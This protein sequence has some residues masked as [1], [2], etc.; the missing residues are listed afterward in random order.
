EQH[1]IVSFS[2]Y[3]CATDYA[4]RRETAQMNRS[5]LFAEGAEHQDVSVP[6]H[7]K[8]NTMNKSS[9]LA[10][11]AMPFLL[12][13]FSSAHALPVPKVAVQVHVA[14]I[15]RIAMSVAEAEAQLQAALDALANAQA[16]GGD[17]AAAQAAVDAAQA[18]L[19]A[20]QMPAAE[21]VPEVAPEPAREAAPE[22]A[23][24]VDEPAPVL[25]PAPEP[26]PVP[27]ATPAPDAAPANDPAPVAEPAPLADTSAPVA[28]PIAPAPDPVPEEL[29]KEK[30]PAV[31]E[32][33][34]E[35]VPDAQMAPDADTTIA[36]PAEQL[37]PAEPAPAADAPEAPKPTPT[38]EPAP[39]TPATD[40]APA[41]TPEAT[42]AGKVDPTAPADVAPA[43]DA[44]ATVD[45]VKIEE[46]KA[47]A[48]DPA[49]TTETIVLPVANGAAVLDSDKEADTQGSGTSRKER[50][51]QRAE[52]EALP[53]PTSDAQAQAL[54]AD[55]GQAAVAPVTI[56]PVEAVAGQKIEQA[57]VFIEQNNVTVQ[58]IINNRTII[59]VDNQIVVRSD[60]RDRL[61]RNA[62]QSFYEQLP[63]GRVR[64]T[65]VKADSSRIVTIRNRF[66]DII[67]RSVISPDGEEYVLFYSPE[68]DRGR[69]QQ[70][71]VDPGDDLPPMRLV[72]PLLDYI[73]DT[74][75][76]PDRDFG[77]FLRKPPVERVER[78]YSLDEVKYSA[79][80]RDKVR[81]IDLDTITF[82]SGRAD[83][84]LKQAN[85]LKS[86]AKAIRSI[87]ARDPGETFL[88]EGHTDAVGSYQSN[89]VLSDQRAESVA[90]I[91]TDVFDIPAENL[92][93]QG[94]G[95]RYLKVVTNGPEELNRRVTI[96]RVTA[97]VRPIAAR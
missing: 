19:A 32:A 22:P 46:N 71:F 5:G 97:L 3:S 73:I 29:K 50:Q 14:G 36:P 16:N 82:A 95:E 34:V 23:P 76:Q 61:E 51:K 83:I 63:R 62:E 58:T 17:V 89:L 84:S 40:A 39:E 43:A 48:A 74:S 26:A 15:T 8:G 66:G 64:E 27:D 52:T 28:E 12:L 53:A 87:L 13:Q 67:Q 35:P 31:E 30:K 94:Y 57:P 65:I 90:N 2:R 55:T 1:I 25:E 81:R 4:L 10:T 79:R 41:A 80:I 92:A 45:P 59:N 20:A 37:A 88:I 42:D 77:A 18:A 47:I 21:P 85:T 72:V 78:V 44:Q 49:K 60:D 54:P 6:G 70:A 91:L 93:T 11:V 96:R 7:T 38:P 75:S 9:L 86:V 68:L 33:P 56:Q 69:A 24:Q